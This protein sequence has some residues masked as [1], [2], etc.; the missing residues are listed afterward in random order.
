MNAERYRD[1]QGADA[2]QKMLGFVGRHLRRG[3]PAARA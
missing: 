2:W 1:K 3:A